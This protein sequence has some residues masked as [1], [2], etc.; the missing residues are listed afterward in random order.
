MK[1]DVYLLLIL[2]IFCV[3]GIN[4]YL[5]IFILPLEDLNLNNIPKP[6]H[7]YYLYFNSITP[8]I[9]ITYED[10][11]ILKFRNYK[12]VTLPE[13]YLGENIQT[14][15]YLYDKDQENFRSMCFSTKVVPRGDILIKKFNLV[16]SKEKDF[17]I[18][19]VD[20]EKC[21]NFQIF[22]VL[23]F[24]EMVIYIL[25]VSILIILGKNYY[26]FQKRVLNN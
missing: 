24:I 15:G 3:L 22:N 20:F 23:K 2:S 9:D 19:I 16:Q 10:E 4:L 26:K 8:I 5:S 11:I 13:K 25:S 1:K 17:L 21:D 14:M 7:R 6:H 18:E 12:D